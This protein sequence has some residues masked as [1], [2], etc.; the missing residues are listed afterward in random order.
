MHI[1]FLTNEYPKEGFPHGGIGSFVKTLAIALVKKG[2]KVSVVG[3]NYTS[4][5]ET[6]NIEGVNIYRLK[7]NK[8]KGLSW[9][10]NF[11]AIN[12]KLREIHKENSIQIVESSE[13]GLAFISKIKAVKYII[14]LHGGHHFFAESEKRKINKWKAFQEK[15][16]LR[17]VMVLS[18]FLI[19]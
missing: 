6:Q 17:K 4:E 13:L 15:N 8:T 3:I 1:C 18:L 19:M 16:H 7:P 12:S 14:R 11:K 10:F 2:I 9:Y 5:T